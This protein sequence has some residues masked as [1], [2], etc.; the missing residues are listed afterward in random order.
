[1]VYAKHIDCMQIRRFTRYNLGEGIQKRQ[2][3]FA[4]EVAA[5]TGQ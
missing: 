5:Q 3:D 2:E 1:M 4:A